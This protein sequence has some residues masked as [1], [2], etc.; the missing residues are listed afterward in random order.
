[1]LY[2]V[3]GFPFGA[4]KT[5]SNPVE[6]WSRIARGS[7]SSRAL[8][9]PEPPDAPSGDVEAMAANNPV[10]SE[11]RWSS[12][13]SWAH[14]PQVKKPKAPFHLHSSRQKGYIEP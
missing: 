4:A 14:N 11:P 1:M 2:H 13:T 12:V 6:P 10:P 9:I 5:I 3:V 8:S 7:P